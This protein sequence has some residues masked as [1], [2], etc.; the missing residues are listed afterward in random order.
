MESKVCLL[1][2][3]CRKDFPVR[4]TANPT[5]TRHGHT[6]MKSD[7]SGDIPWTGVRGDALDLLP[8]PLPIGVR[9]G[10]SKDAMRSDGTIGDGVLRLFRLLLRSTGTARLRDDFSLAGDE[11]G[12]ALQ[13]RFVIVSN[14]TKNNLARGVRTKSDG[15]S[16]RVS[17][18]VKN[19]HVTATPQIKHPALCRI[20]VTSH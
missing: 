1:C 2:D 10:D 6:L 18:T 3:A 12:R 4:I 14:A 5:R 9:G 20:S 7:A 16:T 19:Y 17:V 8:P 11:F 13:A 15:R